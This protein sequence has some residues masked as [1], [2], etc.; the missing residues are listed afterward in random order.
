V[1]TALIKAAHVLLY[2]K[3]WRNIDPER[4]QVVEVVV[5]VVSVDV[6]VVV[7]GK[8]LHQEDFGEEGKNG[9]E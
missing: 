9:L 3:R 6:V 2:E 4:K 1:L 8:L 5:A 7:V